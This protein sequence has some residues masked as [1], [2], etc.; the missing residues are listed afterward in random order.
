MT[1]IFF[2]WMESPFRILSEHSLSGEWAD[3]TNVFS[4]WLWYGH[5]WPWPL[6][7]SVIAGSTV[8][9]VQLLR[10]QN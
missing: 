2:A 8:Y 5:Y 1:G 9:A 6:L 7:G 3:Y 10:I 4:M